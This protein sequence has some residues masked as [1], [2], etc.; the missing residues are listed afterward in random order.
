MKIIFVRSTIIAS[1]GD[2]F[3][4]IKLDTQMVWGLKRSDFD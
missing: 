4:K 1:P 2:H 3:S